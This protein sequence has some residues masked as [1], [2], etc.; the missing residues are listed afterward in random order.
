MW[1]WLCV[2]L[3]F[4]QLFL[5]MWWSQ[6]GS[7]RVAVLLSLFHSRLFAGLWVW[8]WPVLEKCLHP[9]KHEYYKELTR[10]DRAM[11]W[12]IIRLQHFLS[13]F[14]LYHRVEIT[15]FFFT[16]FS[17]ICRIHSKAAW[18]FI[19]HPRKHS[20]M[21]FKLVFTE[22]KHAA[23]SLPKFCTPDLGTACTC[24]NSP[25]CFVIVISQKKWLFLI[26][27]AAKA[28]ILR[29]NFARP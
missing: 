8:R 16:S 20:L 27:G 1:T 2:G 29:L 23:L 10:P 5:R 3:E 12:W 21:L 26:P 11:Q 22:T 24:K 17:K 14:S 7:V 25:G 4:S 9:L 13:R 6:K 19:E 28:N 18:R 15:F